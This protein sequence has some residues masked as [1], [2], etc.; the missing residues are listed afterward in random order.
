MRYRILES[1][2]PLRFGPLFEYLESD[3]DFAVFY[4]QLLAG[5]EFQAFFWELPAVTLKTLDQPAEFVLMDAPA[6]S[7]R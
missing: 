1:G 3:S 7:G 4:T 6:L 2:S 5:S